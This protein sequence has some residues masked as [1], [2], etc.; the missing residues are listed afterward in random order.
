VFVCP[1]Y[2]FCGS[3]YILKDVFHSGRLMDLHALIK[4]KKLARVKH[5]SVFGLSNE[6]EKKIRHGNKI[7]K[8]QNKLECLLIFSVKGQEPTL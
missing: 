6:K 8:R 4:L 1:F 7:T 5:F 3:G 2:A